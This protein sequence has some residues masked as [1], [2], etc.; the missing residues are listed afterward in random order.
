MPLG[1]Q[2]ARKDLLSSNSSQGLP[3]L[4]LLSF[5]LFSLE[6]VIMLRCTRIWRRQDANKRDHEDIDDCEDNHMDVTDQDTKDPTKNSSSSSSSS[7]SD[8]VMTS[9]RAS[10]RA[11]YEHDDLVRTPFPEFDMEHT[12]AEGGDMPTTVSDDETDDESAIAAKEKKYSTKEDQDVAVFL[13]LTKQMSLKSLLHLLQGQARAQN[14]SSTYLHQYEAMAVAAE[15]QATPPSKPLTKKAKQFRFAEVRDHQVRVVVH[16]VDSYKEQK[17]LWWSS[18]EMTAIRSE[19]VK[20]VRFFR[21]HRPEYIHAVQMVAQ[22]HEE[23]GEQ[24]KELEEHM[25][26][27]TEDSYARGLETHIVSLFGDNRK[28]AIEAVL[29]EQSECHSCGD[30]E[31]LTR[32]CLREQ[33]QAYSQMSMRFASK[34]GQ[35]DQ[36]DALKAS[37]SRWRAV[38][39]QSVAET[40][41]F[42]NAS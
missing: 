20:A 28:A 2:Q 4:T 36:I 37:M 32:H 38:S 16:E 25:R 13:A 14:L 34:M 22:S 42:W 40:T 8:V 39:P 26:L 15:H 1:Y 24:C 7:S 33:Q 9:S 10:K 6:V 41:D 30:D 35:C 12:V 5:C 17:D 27:L 3:V 29:Q 21:K 18:E 19:V 23:D 31:E 11:K